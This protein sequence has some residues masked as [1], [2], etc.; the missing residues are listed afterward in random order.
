M[1]HWWPHNKHIK[2]AKYCSRY[3]VLELYIYS[4]NTFKCSNDSDKLNATIDF[5]L[6]LEVWGFG[7]VYCQTDGRRG[8]SQIFC[9]RNARWAIKTTAL[10]DNPVAKYILRN[11]TC[12]WIMEQCF[13]TVTNLWWGVWLAKNTFV[14]GKMGF[15]RQN[16]ISS[17]SA[18]APPFYRFLGHGNTRPPTRRQFTMVTNRCVPESAE[19]YGQCQNQNKVTCCQ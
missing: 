4:L 8:R 14:Q 7:L 12:E 5:D 15:L 2:I 1:A 17:P 3:R 11:A 13:A 9:V 6:E 19:H 18:I 10:G 16:W